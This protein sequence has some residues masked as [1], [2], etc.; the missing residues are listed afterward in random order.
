MLASGSMRFQFPAAVLAGGAS[1]RMGLP[2]AALPYGRTTLLAHQT[3]RLAGLFEHVMVV[4]KE[5]PDFEVGPARLVLDGTAEQAPIYGLLAAL[6][7]TKDR[8]FVLAVDLPLVTSAV[9]AEIARRGMETAAAALVPLADGRLQPLAAVW[10]RAV[11]STAAE[12]IERRELS[13]HGLAEKCGAE[14]LAESEWRRFDPSGNAFA[15]LNT[16]Q[17]YVAA[18]ERG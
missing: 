15:N 13:L 7:Q 8:V 3:E 12:R 14:I 1:R 10:S 2:K 17:D 5:E 6:A 9:I 11:I 18:R 16:L 4:A